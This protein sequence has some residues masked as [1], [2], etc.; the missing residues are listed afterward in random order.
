MSVL[1]IRNVP[2][3]LL[4]RLKVEAAETGTTMREVVL[5]VLRE[6]VERKGGARK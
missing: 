3:D 6:H 1:S 4:R 2:A 5:R